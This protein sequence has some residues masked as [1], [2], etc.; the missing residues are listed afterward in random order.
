MQNSLIQDAAAVF[1]M[2]A[3]RALHCWYPEMPP[4][5]M[6]GV[7]AVMRAALN[8]PLRNPSHKNSSASQVSAGE[9]L[10]C[11]VRVSPSR[12]YLTLDI[13]PRGLDR[14]STRP[15]SLALTLDRSGSIIIETPTASLFL[16]GREVWDFIRLGPTKKDDCQSTSAQPHGP[17][18]LSRALEVALKYKSRPL[19]KTS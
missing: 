15:A 3:E 14:G 9:T 4:G 1:P 16:L 2:I 11:R 12:V 8:H 6:A 7:S 13:G 19:Q 5:T 10:T 18:A 17:Q